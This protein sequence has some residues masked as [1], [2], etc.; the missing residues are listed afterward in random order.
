MS[1]QQ[2]ELFIFLGFAAVTLSFLVCHAV[3]TYKRAI[4]KIKNN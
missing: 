2:T 3:W 1:D 4:S